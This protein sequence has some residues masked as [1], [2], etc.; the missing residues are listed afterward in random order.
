[1]GCGMNK[2]CQKEKCVLDKTRES[3]VVRVQHMEE[4]YDL[5]QIAYNEYPEKIRKDPHLNMAIH[6]LCQYTE[7]GVW[8]QDFQ[9]DERGEIPCGVKRGVLSEDG[10]YNL[11]NDI[12]EYLRE[13]Q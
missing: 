7:S 8:L 1:M 9:C 2:E 10:L 6:R 12:A 5:L 3:V 13:A 11:L 4:L